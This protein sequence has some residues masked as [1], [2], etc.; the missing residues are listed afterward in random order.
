MGGVLPLLVSFGKDVVYPLIDKLFPDAEEREKAKHEYDVLVAQGKLKE[1]EA[2]MNIIVAE[3]K[4]DSWLARNCRPISMLTL[5]ALTVSWFMGWCAPNVTPEIQAELMT[6][7]QICIGGYI[8][9][10]T[11]DKAFTSIKSK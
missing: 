10:R 7:V 8:G 6:L 1:M 9:G 4:S 3:A 5:L 2:A 11:V